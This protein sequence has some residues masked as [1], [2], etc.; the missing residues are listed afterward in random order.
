LAYLKFRYISFS[1]TVQAKDQLLTAKRNECDL[2]LLAWLKAYRCSCRN[3][4][5]RPKRRR[6][7]KAERP[8]DLKE[9]IMRPDLYG[10]VSRVD[11][12]QR[13]CRAIGIQRERSRNGEDLAWY[14]RLTGICGPHAFLLLLGQNSLRFVFIARGLPVSAA[15]KS[16]DFSF[17][18]ILLMHLERLLSM[19]S[20][21]MLLI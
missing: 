21:T 13:Q 4:E 6:P 2:F 3:V 19:K 10:P 11:Y 8:I 18:Q 14:D 17:C 1:E 12:D 5:P 9:M 7:V 20:N 15:Q 16:V